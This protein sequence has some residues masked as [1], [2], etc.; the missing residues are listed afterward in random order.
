MDLRRFVAVL[1]A[2]VVLLLDMVSLSFGNIV[3][4]VRHKFAGRECSLSA[5]KAHD[6]LRHRRI[7]SAVDLP[8]GGNGHPAD[9]GLYFAKI[10]LGNPSNEY[11]VQVD[12]GSD[13][14]WVNCANCKRCPTKSDLGVKLTLYDPKS[15]DSSSMIYCNDNFC[16]S[17]YNGIL[18]GC[19]KGV[20]CQYSVS[21][22]DGS[23]TTGFFVKDSVNFDRVIGNHQTASA[24]G[25]IIFG[26]GAQ[27]SGEL[28]TSSE[29]VDGILG[30]GQANSSVISQLASAGKVKRVFAHCLDNTNGG[31]IFAIGEVFS[32]KVNT[33]PMVPNQPHYNVVMKDIEVGGSVLQLPT[34]VFDSGDRKG[35]IIDSGTTLA[36]FPEVVYETMMSKILEQQPGIKLHTIEQQFSCFQYT[37]K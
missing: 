20:P 12:T 4:D 5:L 16:T 29:A 30:F 22:G 11:Y 15:S 2:V 6:A 17:T 7:L 31:G 14:L 27:Q 18:P 19:T 34:D 36:Y 13:I 25:T 9:A 28:G 33:T 23:T 35:T 26:C 21:Y 8:L 1:A 37:G 24:N 10:G 32:P 3:F